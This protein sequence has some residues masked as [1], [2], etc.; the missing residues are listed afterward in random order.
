M[1]GL[2]S[3]DDGLHFKNDPLH[4]VKCNANNVAFGA[5]VLGRAPRGLGGNCWLYLPSGELALGDDRQ[6]NAQ[7]GKPPTRN[8]KTMPPLLQNKL[9][10]QHSLADVQNKPPSHWWKLRIS[11]RLE[12]GWF[13]LYRVTNYLVPASFGSWGRPVQTPPSGQDTQQEIC[14]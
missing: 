10:M 13:H 5:A 8:G 7:M 4:K 12:F 2:F 9:H 6:W 1:A 11:P 14:T 3:T